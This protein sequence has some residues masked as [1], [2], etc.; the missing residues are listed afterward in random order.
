MGIGA[1][2][3]LLGTAKADGDLG[4][5]PERVVGEEIVEVVGRGEPIVAEVGA[6]GQV[7]QLRHVMNQPGD[8]VEAGKIKAAEI[9]VVEKL[10]PEGEL[11]VESLADLRRVSDPDHRRDDDVANPAAIDQRD[12]G[13]VIN[14]HPGLERER[15][16][17]LHPLQDGLLAQIAVVRAGGGVALLDATLGQVPGGEHSGRAA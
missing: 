7:A 13:G 16:V 6:Q 10:L 15:L 11:A 5:E 8:G 3:N 2:R 17:F 12:V 4:T 9:L 14:R 1:K